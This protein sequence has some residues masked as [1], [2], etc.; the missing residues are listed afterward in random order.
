MKMPSINIKNFKIPK[1]KVYGIDVIKNFLFFF[2]YIILTLFIIATILAPSVKLFKKTKNYYFQIKENFETTQKEYQQLFSQLQS[3]KEKNKK[4]IN[5]LQNHFNINDFKLFAKK[6]MQI[7]SIQKQKTLPYKEK[8]ITTSYLIT[9]KIK[10]PEDF[11][12]FIDALKNYKNLIRVYFP[13]DFVKEKN[14]IKL[15][16]KIEVYNLKNRL[17]AEE[18]AH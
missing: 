4:I 15:T 5:N 8:F 3:L 10:S 13:F 14:E 12:K 9:A 7:I 17:K 6:Y 16:F 18:K 2:F 11:Y 1:I